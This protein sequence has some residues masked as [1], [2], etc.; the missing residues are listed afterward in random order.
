MN[1]TT[2]NIISGDNTSIFIRRPSYYRRGRSSNK[3]HICFNDELSYNVNLYFEAIKLFHDFYIEHMSHICYYKVVCGISLRDSNDK[4]IQLYNDWNRKM[5]NIAIFLERVYENSKMIDYG[6]QFRS[7]FNSK[8][9]HKIVPFTK[10]QLLFN[11][12]INPKL[13]VN[14][15]RFFIQYTSGNA[16][17]VKL[18]CIN[19]I[20]KNKQ[21]CDTDDSKFAGPHSI[22]VGQV[23]KI[24]PGISIKKYD[25]HYRVDCDDS[26]KAT[27]KECIKGKTKKMGRIVNTK[28]TKNRKG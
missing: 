28:C 18:D 25:K 8:W 1:N 3:I 26:P 19:K 27:S 12:P 13:N 15:G 17:N 6:E 14:D 5:P 11:N 7:Y 2:Y 10:S 22:C 9:K 21:N 23:Y 4:V 20:M 24:K 16:G